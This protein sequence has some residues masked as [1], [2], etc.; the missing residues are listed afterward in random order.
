MKRLDSWAN[1]LFTGAREAC[2]G[3]NIS[4]ILPV[5]RTKSNRPSRTL[6]DF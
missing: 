4:R 6:L 5:V 1:I 2:L 3:Q